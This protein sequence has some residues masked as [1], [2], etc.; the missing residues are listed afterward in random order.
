MP[1]IAIEIKHYERIVKP[2]LKKIEEQ[3]EYINKLLNGKTKTSKMVVKHKRS[4]T[5]SE[6]ISKKT[7]Y[8][9]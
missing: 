2:L 3:E 8:S 5:N 7:R 1:H 4:K 9:F 6:R